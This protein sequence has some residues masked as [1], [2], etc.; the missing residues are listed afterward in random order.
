MAIL[1][2]FESVLAFRRNMKVVRNVVIPCR[3]KLE[4]AFLSFFFEFQVSGETKKL[5]WLIGIDR[6]DLWCFIAHGLILVDHVLWYAVKAMEFIREGYLEDA[7][8]SNLVETSF[9]ELSVLVSSFLKLAR[10]F[11][12]CQSHVVAHEPIVLVTCRNEENENIPLCYHVVDN[13]QIQFGKEEFCLVIGLKFGVENRTDYND[14]AKEIPFRR[15]VFSSSLDG[16]PIR[17]KHVEKLI[18]SKAFNKLDD[19]DVVSLCCVGILQLVLLGLEDRRPVSNWILRLANDRDGWDK[20]PW[21]SHVWPTL[22][23][24]LKDAN[25]RRCPALYATQATDEVDK[26]SYSITGFAWAFKGK[27]HVERLVP[28]EIEAR[29]RWWVSSRAYFDGRNIEDERIPRHLNRNNLFEVP[30]EMY[31]EFEEQRRGYKQMMQK[32]DDMYKKMSRFMED[33]GVGPNI[34]DRARREHHPSIYK[35]SPYTVLPPT[36]VLPKKRTNK[37]KKKGKAAKLS[38]LNLGNTFAN[39]NVLGEEVTITGVQQTDNCFYEN[40]DPDKHMNSWIQILIRERAENDN[41]TLSKSGTICVHPENNRF[42]ILTDPHIT[43]HWMVQYVHTHHGR[44]LTG[45]FNGT[46]RQPRNFQFSY[47]DFFGYTVPQQQNAKDCGVITCWLIT[48][49]C[50]R[51]PPIV[52]GD[53]QVYWDNMR[54]QMCQKFYNCRCEDSENYGYD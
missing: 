54:Y 50:L 39:E 46:G 20:Y 22:Y 28:D 31:R 36:T 5:V 13:F 43:E 7:A 11:W 49:L 40:V 51:Q 12:L 19:N 10:E 35:Q 14:E 44:M 42:M 37:T 8:E 38:P 29:S 47:N 23:Q 6:P 21:G 32:S 34:C 53:S 30:S 27:L 1:S 17:G 26:K 52:V 45:Y 41:W 24:Q 3:E 2:T 25:V 9:Q 18:K 4:G 33:T 16:R 48:K 15:M